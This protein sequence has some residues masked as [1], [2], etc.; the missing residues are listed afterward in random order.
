ME[1]TENGLVRIENAMRQRS[2]AR[3]DYKIVLSKGD[4]ITE[5]GA[6]FLISGE[7]APKKQGEEST[8]FTSRVVCVGVKR[9]SKSLYGT[10]GTK[11][12]PTGIQFGI[13]DS[14]SSK[15]ETANNGTKYNR[16]LYSFKEEKA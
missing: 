12:F 3:E 5:I 13:I 6:S 2:D 7:I 11:S 1:T 8:P 15:Q 10:V 9:G 16:T 4:R 14:V